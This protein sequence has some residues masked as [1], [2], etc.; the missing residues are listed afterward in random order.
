MCFSLVA[1]S[2]KVLEFSP[3]KM[4]DSEKNSLALSIG[5]RP[6]GSKTTRYSRDSIYFS[7]REISASDILGSIISEACMHDY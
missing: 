2:L 7:K 5:R 1:N 6:D 3:L 4:N